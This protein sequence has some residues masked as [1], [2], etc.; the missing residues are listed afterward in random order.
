M[1]RI[2]LVVLL[3]MPAAVL[4]AGDAPATDQPIEASML[5]TGSLVIE[6]DGSVSSHGVD[7]AEEVPDYVLGHIA[8]AVPRWRFEPVVV[9]GKIVR[10]RARMT[11][12]M[13]ATPLDDGGLAVSLGAA[14]FGDRYPTGTDYISGVRMR[15][16]EYPSLALRLGASGTVYMVLK[17]GR[18]G[19]TAEAAVEQV[20]LR[21][22][23]DARTMERVRTHM[24]V[25]ALKAARRWTFTPP[26]TGPEVDDPWWSVRIPVDF[27]M[28]GL[29]QREEDSYGRW[30][31][32]VPGPRNAAP[33]VI[34]D[35]SLGNDAIAAGSLEQAGTGYRL[36]TPLQ[37]EG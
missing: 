20:N 30:I 27:T 17:V 7:R 33:W 23:G 34:E 1:L 18:D 31:G 4:Q 14:T 3:A 32:Y 9:D 13:L 19:R 25:A 15:P 5:V 36:L 6:P 26:S 10:A 22:I 29:D 2:L 11:L 28:F 37:P 12:R 8:R 21:S 16:P 24:S 35:A